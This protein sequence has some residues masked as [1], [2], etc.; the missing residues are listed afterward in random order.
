MALSSSA[1]WRNKTIGRCWPWCRDGWAMIQNLLPIVPRPALIQIQ[2]HVQIQTHWYK[3]KHIDT[4]TNTNCASSR[5]DTNTNTC[6]YN[7]CLAP[8]LIQIQT[9]V[10][11]IA[12]YMNNNCIS[13]KV[14]QYQCVFHSVIFSE[15]KF[16]SAE[17]SRQMVRMFFFFHSLEKCQMRQI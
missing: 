6:T 7:K 3:Y 12:Q 16:G 14:I 4:N 8:A 1:C 11:Q 9:H 10:Q 13:A 17:G 2:T 5:I 15:V